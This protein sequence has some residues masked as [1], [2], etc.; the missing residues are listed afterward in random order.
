MTEFLK[1]LLKTPQGAIGFLIVLLVLIVVAFGPIIATHDPEKMSILFRYKAPSASFWLGT[2]QYGRDIFS[3]LM[4]G[5]RATV[6]MA[7]LATIAGT[8]IGALIGTTSA[9]LGAGPTSSSC[10]RSMP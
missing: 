1:R 5:A 4:I 10:A 7:V 3:R 6:V 9:F 2:D 8:L